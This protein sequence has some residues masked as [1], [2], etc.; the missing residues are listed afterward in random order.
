MNVN[1]MKEVHFSFRQVGNGISGYHYQLPP[2][3]LA[4]A[5]R[6]FFEMGKMGIVRKSNSPWASPLHIVP[7]PNGGWRPCGDYRRLHNSTTPD[8]YPIPHFLD[9][10][11]QLEGKTISQK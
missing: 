5:K 2:D 8:R 4:A 1:K 6:G 3:K 9:F 11:A 7:K 10:A